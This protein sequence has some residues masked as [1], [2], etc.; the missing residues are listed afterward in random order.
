SLASGDS[1]G[2]VQWYDLTTLPETA[3][4]LPSQSGRVSAMDFSL[5]GR[6][7]ATG[8]ENG[9]VRLWSLDNP[10]LGYPV[11]AH[12]SIV[13]GLAYVSGA[14]GEKLVSTGYDGAVRLWDYRT[15][16]AAPET[17]RGH[18]GVINLL[19]AAPSVNGFVTSGHDRTL[20]IWSITSP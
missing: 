7:L 17:V 6:W 16:G 3:Q 1:G 19:G 9:V 8:D 18:D 12:E 2:G 15:P 11:R 5:N 4:R 13:S 14:D 20:R 10:A